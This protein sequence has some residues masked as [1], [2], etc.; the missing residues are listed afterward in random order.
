M[1]FIVFLPKETRTYQNNANS[2]G[3]ICA[4]PISAALRLSPSSNLESV[5]DGDTRLPVEARFGML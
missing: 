1:L 3:P 2:A 4:G 5:F